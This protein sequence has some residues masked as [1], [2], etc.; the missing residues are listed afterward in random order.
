MLEKPEEGGRDLPSAISRASQGTARNQACFKVLV[1]KGPGMS[2]LEM[3][4]TWSL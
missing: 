2:K 4:A 1:G 3:T